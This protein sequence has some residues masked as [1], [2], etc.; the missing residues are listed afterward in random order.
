MFFFEALVM[1]D[2]NVMCED[3]KQWFGSIVW[4]KTLMHGGASSSIQDSPV[5]LHVCVCDVRRN[6]KIS[7]SEKGKDEKANCERTWLQEHD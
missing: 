3:F 5:L 2:Q 4:L 1:L 7:R 6:K